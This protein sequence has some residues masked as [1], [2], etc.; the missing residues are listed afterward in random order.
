MTLLLRVP[1]RNFSPSSPPSASFSNITGHPLSDPDPLVSKTIYVSNR[2]SPSLLATVFDRNS[3]P[4]LIR[5]RGRIPIQCGD[6]STIFRYLGG[7]LS[8]N[9]DWKK[10]W[11]LARR[12]V[13]FELGKLAKSRLTLPE[14]MLA[15]QYSI[16][17]KAGYFLPLP[18]PSLCPR[19]LG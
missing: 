5:P 4:G 19:R 11:P 1:T 6:S 13:D 9:L 17:G 15:V 14:L 10:L 16:V 8:L 12:S 3:R 7:Y 18:I 2:S